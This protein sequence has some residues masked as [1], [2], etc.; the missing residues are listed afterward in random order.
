[1]S[2]ISKKEKS[3]YLSD[4]LPKQNGN[5]IKPVVVVFDDVDIARHHL[6]LQNFIVSH[7]TRNVEKKNCIFLFIC[8]QAVTKDQLIAYNGGMKIK[9]VFEHDTDFPTWNEEALDKL[10]Q[11]QVHNLTKA[12]VPHGIAFITVS[13]MCMVTPLLLQENA[14]NTPLSPAQH[15]LVLKHAVQ[16]GSPGFVLD[17]FD[18]DKPVCDQQALTDMASKYTKM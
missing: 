9:P 4:L 17:V 1:M 13:L 10:L 18:R 12:N 7:S 2:G 16:I 6:Q 5:E 3:T 15:A 8:K 11:E 14:H